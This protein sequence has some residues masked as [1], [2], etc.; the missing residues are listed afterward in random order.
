MEFLIANWLGILGLITGLLCVWLLIKEH[1]YTF[2]LGLAY[3]L[4]TV[5]VMLEA[6]L[7]AD[8]LLN[9]YYV[10]MNAYGWYFWLQGGGERRSAETL[11]VAWLSTSARLTA[12]V[13]TAVGT[14][15]LGT[16]FATQTDADF[17]Y[18]D[19]F[20]TM[21]SFIAMWMSARKYIDSWIV[22]LIVDVISVAL[23]LLKA[24]GDPTL[25]YYA[26]LYTIYLWMAVVGYRAWHQHLPIPRELAT[27]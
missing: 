18:A 21:A 20:T 17:A 22:W 26:V 27:K 25:Y 9:G 14:L 5:V 12:L 7:Y 10:L 6:K 11:R 16:Y 2:P 19:S 8:V 3:A 24:D 15:L 1:I 4:I 23:Y 13:A